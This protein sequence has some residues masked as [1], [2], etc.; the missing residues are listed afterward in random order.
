[1]PNC[2]TSQSIIIVI[3]MAWMEAVKELQ[4][5]GGV[6]LRDTLLQVEQLRPPGGRSK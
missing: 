1:M 6:W 2:A 3:S 4:L 5:V